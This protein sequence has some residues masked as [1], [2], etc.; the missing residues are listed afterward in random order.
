[1]HELDA[2]CTEGTEFLFWLSLTGPV[3]K[4]MTSVGLDPWGMMRLKAGLFTLRGKCA[5]LDEWYI[6]WFFFEACVTIETHKFKTLT[7]V[8]KKALMTVCGGRA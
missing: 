6:R 8:P 7:D 1:M 4:M 3:A 2:E 5:G